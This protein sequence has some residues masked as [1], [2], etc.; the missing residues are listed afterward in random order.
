MFL[1]NIIYSTLYQVYV[2]DYSIDYGVYCH[3]FEQYFS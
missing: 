2:I 3:F 1:I